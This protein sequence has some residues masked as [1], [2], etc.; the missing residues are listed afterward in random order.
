MQKTRLKKSIDRPTV[1]F[2]QPAAPPDT[3]D[4]TSN[5]S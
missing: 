4:H 2:P 5:T 1:T 3:F